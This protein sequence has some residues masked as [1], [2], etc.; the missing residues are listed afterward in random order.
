MEGKFKIIF[1]KT[2]KAYSP[3]KI[4]GA[5]WAINPYIGCEHACK[6]CYAKFM[7]AYYNYGKWGSWIVVRE[8]LPELVKGKHVSGIVLMSTVSD[9]YQPVERKF[10]LTR[11][12]LAHMSKSVKL[13]ILTKSNLVLRDV[14]L[15]KR[16]ACI[17]VGLTVNSFEGKLK[18]EIE[19]NSPA[20]EK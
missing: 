13:S 4:P 1:T 5:K 15:F 2:R 17:E 10:E 19:P 12:I 8:N 7:C 6:Y 16:F 9:A 14:D 18:K 3:T 11:K 20:S